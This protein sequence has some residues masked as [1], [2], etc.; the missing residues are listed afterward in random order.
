MRNDK[1]NKELKEEEEHDGST[2]TQRYLERG[3]RGPLDSSLTADSKSPLRSA[4]GVDLVTELPFATSSL[5]YDAA[6]ICR[7]LW[8][9]FCSPFELLT[10]LL[11]G[12]DVGSTRVTSHASCGRI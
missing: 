11:E 9:M 2:P 6:I 4:L 12:G 8:L 5:E 1:D 3:D 7:L 10:V